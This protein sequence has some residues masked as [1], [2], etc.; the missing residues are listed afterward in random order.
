MVSLDI[1]SSIDATGFQH[2][3]PALEESRSLLLASILSPALSNEI[4]TFA[5][6]V[7]T[8]ASEVL[9]FAREVH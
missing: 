7:L 2:F 9:T 6:E 3:D 8:F 1:Q 5:H 4:S